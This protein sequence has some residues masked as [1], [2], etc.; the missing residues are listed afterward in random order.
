M[1]E[2]T[3][4]KA[5]VSERIRVNFRPY[6]VLLTNGQSYLNKKAAALLDIKDGDTL[7]FYI[8]EDKTSWYMVNDAHSGAGISKK[9]GVFKFCD[10]KLAK[11]IFDTYKVPG[12]KKA[13]FYLGD[14]LQEF[15]GV[16]ALYINPN[17]F[18]ID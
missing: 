12:K 9:Q 11:R 13:F 8:S 14:C 17:A 1:A 10:T 2:I 16:K 15:S 7:A 5:E 3:L 18:N 4:I 6:L